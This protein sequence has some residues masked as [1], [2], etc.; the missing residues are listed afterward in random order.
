LV[1]AEHE[2]EV[3]VVVKVRN[4]S[5]RGGSVSVREGRCG[6]LT[7]DKDKWYGSDCRLM[8]LLFF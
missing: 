6:V 7:A 8:K 3:E 5:G 2:Q 4:Y 1:V